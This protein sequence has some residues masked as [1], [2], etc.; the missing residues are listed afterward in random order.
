MGTNFGKILGPTGRDGNQLQRNAWG[1][2]AK[3]W[4]LLGPPCQQVVATGFAGS[5]RESPGVVSSPKRLEKIVGGTP[6]QKVVATGVVGS[7]RENRWGYPA[8]KYLLPESPGAAGSRRE[9][10]V[11]RND[12]RKSLGAPCQKVVATE[13]VGSRR[14]SPRVTYSPKRLEKIVG[15]TLP[16]SSCYRSRRGPPGVT[17]SRQ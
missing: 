17:G 10:P 14:E 9:S 13:V 3:K 2:P 12:S 15:G 7:L 5:H 6:C 1:H 8:S 4:L 11:A 16:A